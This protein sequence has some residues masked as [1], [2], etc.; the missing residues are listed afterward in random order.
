MIL[1]VDD[2][3]G[4]IGDVAE[5]LGAWRGR[6]DAW[7]LDGFAPALHPGM[8][9]DE[10]LALVAARSAPGAGAATFTVAGQVRRGLAAAGFAVER[11]PGHGRKRVRLV[12]RLPGVPGPDPWPPRVAIVGAGVAGA[13][14][15]RCAVR[16]VSRPSPALHD[17][18]LPQRSRAAES[19]DRA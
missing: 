6:A 1:A 7:F 13:A 9:R 16:L 17:V 11:R 14:A 15:A 18:S 8:W 3:I 12:A 19:R 4:A 5:A 10:V 2:L